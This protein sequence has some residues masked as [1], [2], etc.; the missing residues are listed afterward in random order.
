MA[1]PGHAYPQVTV[2]A[3][4]LVNAQVVPLPGGSVA[5]TALAAALAAGAAVLLVERGRAVVRED[6]VRAFALGLGRVPAE[7]LARPMPSVPREAGELTVRRRLAGGAPGVLVADGDEP[8]G[9][10]M[11]SASAPAAAGPSVARVLESVLRP[12]VDAVLRRVARVAA[13]AG[14]R[15]YAVGG[16]VRDAL[17]GARAPGRRDVDVVIAGDGRAVARLLASEIGARLT[18]HDRFLTASLA[19]ATGLRIDVVTA[20]A[21][22]YDAPGV[23]PRVRPAGIA[24]DLRR[25]DFS[26][27]AMAVDLGDDAWPLLDPLGGRADLARRR[28]R[29][30][31]PLSFVEDPTRLFRA[32]RYAVRLG[33]RLDA[34]TRECRELAL[35]L[36]PCE[37]LSGARVQAELALLLDEPRGETAL[38]AL[39]R[40]GVLRLLD[41]RYRF[42]RAT[43]RRLRELAGARAWARARGLPAADLELL[44]V[45][46][47]AGQSPEIGRRALGRLGLTGEP[48]ERVE[49]ALTLAGQGGGPRAGERRSA[50]AR[51]VRAR[52]PLELAW[53]WLDADAGTRQRLA[54]AVDEDLPVAPWL[55]GDELTAMGVRG[56]AVARLLGELRDA[57]LDGTLRDRAAAEAYVRGWRP[58]GPGSAERGERADA[59]EG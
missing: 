7:R 48:R 3:A 57:R 4:D 39:A 12:E 30:L 52:S 36:L 45:A 22:H 34:W 24:A 33:F 41:T 37:A 54:D 50:R 59:G 15:A 9:A 29:V 25:R 43:A 31:H 13:Q 23:L 32:A 20:R 11:P 51:A 16:L 6:L 27:N 44:L 26:V 14:S 58:G 1:R 42:T 17:L 8:V 47:L 53:L 38:L 28:L 40:V 5:E 18:E 49:R 19:T 21:E 35:A 10:V 2:T 56:P 46:L 55:S